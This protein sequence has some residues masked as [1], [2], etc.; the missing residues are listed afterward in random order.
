[1]PQHS[2]YRRELLLQLD[3]QPR[4][5]LLLLRRSSVRRMPHLIETTLIA[6]ADAVGIEALGMGTHTSQRTSHLYLAITQDVEMVADETLVVHLHV[7]VIQLQ[8]R[9]TAVT[10]GGSTMDD[11]H[12]NQSLHFLFLFH[13]L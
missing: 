7:V 11:K 5:R 4:H 12:R 13:K 1:M 6:D 3:N 2:M 9:V 10:T 8:Q